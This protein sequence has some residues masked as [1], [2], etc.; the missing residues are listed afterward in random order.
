MKF[1][2][3]ILHTAKDCRGSISAP[4]IS[5]HL[6]VRSGQIFDSRFQIIKQLG[7]GQHST[8]W[9]A[10]SDGGLKALKILTSDV[11]ALQGKEAFELEVLKNIASAQ[12]GL[13]Q[14]RLLQLED[15][16]NIHG[17]HGDHLCLVTVPLGPSLLEVCSRLE[18]TCLPVP[19]VKR[20]T[21]QLLEALNIL[22]GQCQI[23][24][25]DIKAD[26]IMFSTAFLSENEE[27]DLDIINEVDIVLVD[28]GTAIPPNGPHSR[29]IQPTA[30]RSP[31]VI[32]GCV[33]DFKVDIWNLGCIVFELITG[34]HLFKP[35]ASATWSAEQYHLAR[36][37]ATSYTKSLPSNVM[38][39]FRRGQHF[40]KYFDDK[41]K[42][43]TME[44]ILRAH[45]VY[46]PELHAILTA[47]LQI[48][49]DDRLSAKDL[50]GFDWLREEV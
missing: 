1:V 47:M 3:R 19:L 31:E 28:F 10:R 49:P 32:T 27:I 33:W 9:L 23:V 36:I 41:G 43:E 20:V 38:D 24:H 30:L 16:F 14:K 6:A 4:S 42:A 13:S 34:Q 17:E 18:S 39:F 21:R 40:E 45:K 50:L 12:S 44:K 7:S 15:H 26:N 37:F 11:T 35:K 22:H 2:S 46:T 25:T 48:L 8:V 29:L 5:R